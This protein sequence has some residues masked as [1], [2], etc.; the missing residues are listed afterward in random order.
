MYVEL[1]GAVNPHV[2]R[3]S[4]PLFGSSNAQDYLSLCF[5]L[6]ACKGEQVAAVGSLFEAFTRNR[7]T[8]IESAS[9]FCAPVAR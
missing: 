8:L 3:L 2:E 4:L 7:Q 6:D 5:R 1:T 9:L